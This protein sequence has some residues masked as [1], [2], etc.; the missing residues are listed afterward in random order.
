MEYHEIAKSTGIAA[1]FLSNLESV[2]NQLIYAREPLVMSVNLHD[3]SFTGHLSSMYSTLS[4]SLVKKPT[5]SQA[6][7]D[8][9]IGAPRSCQRDNQAG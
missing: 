2:V 8:S 6:R 7:A 1:S 3:N 9:E 5:I 4:S